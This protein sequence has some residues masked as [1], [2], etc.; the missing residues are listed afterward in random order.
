MFGNR[1]RRR[2]CGNGKGIAVY[3][4]FRAVV[5]DFGRV[6]SVSFGLDGKACWQRVILLPNRAE[7]RLLLWQTL[8]QR[9]M[10]E[11]IV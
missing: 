11:V 1:N 5:D 3:F 4:R 2:R 10:K 8:L 9:S 6:P 7:Y